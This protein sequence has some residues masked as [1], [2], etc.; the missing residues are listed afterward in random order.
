MITS[1]HSLGL[2]LATRTSKWLV[3]TTVSLTIWYKTAVYTEEYAKIS[4]WDAVQI[5]KM[6]KS[7]NDHYQNEDQNFTM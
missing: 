2:K 5:L 1:L 6:A 4:L 7:R 3:L